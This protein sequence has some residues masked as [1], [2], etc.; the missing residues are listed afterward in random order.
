[1]D[2]FL[3]NKVCTLKIKVFKKI[4]WKKSYFEYMHTW[5]DAQL[6]QKIFDG[7]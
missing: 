1:M 4:Y 3:E 7:L 6:D 2:T 5:F